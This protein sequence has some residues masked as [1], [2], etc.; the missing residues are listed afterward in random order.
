MVAGEEQA[1]DDLS[2]GAQ[3]IQWMVVSSMEFR[4]EEGALWG[5]WDNKRQILSDVITL[6]NLLQ[7]MDPIHG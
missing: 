6:Y 2:T 5:Q 1:C 4:E 7:L 3:V